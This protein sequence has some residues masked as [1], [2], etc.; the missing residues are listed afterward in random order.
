L[1]IAIKLGEEKLKL[2]LN[3]CK[4]ETNT[5]TE[6][7]KECIKNYIE[8]DN[9]ELYE[10]KFGENVTEYELYHLSTVSQNLINWYPF[11][12]KDTVLQIGGDLGELTQVFC[13]NCEKVVTIEPNI[14]KAK[15]IA[16]R[17]ENRENLEIIV[18]NIDDIILEEKFSII[19]II[20][21]NPKIKLKDNIQKLERNLKE[22][23]KFI[24]AVDNK[25]G[26][27]YFMGN[28]ENI[29]NKKFESLIGY[30]N[31]P[32]KIESFTKSSLE[33]IFNSIGYKYTFYYPLPDYKMPNVIF[34]E[35][36]KAKY[37]SIDKYN[38]YY[39]ENS[40][41]IA[42]EIDV[43]REILKT[44]QQMFEFF[45]N[46]FLIILEK[47]KN[48]ELPL[49][50]SYNNMRKEKYRLITKISKNVVEKKPVSKE[51]EGHYNNIKKNIELLQQNN[52]KTVD[53]IENG[54]IKSK[55]INQENLLNT[56]LT[57]SLEENNQQEFE[58]IIEKYIQNLKK[59]KKVEP[60]YKDTIFSKYN[61]QIEDKNI[62][63][64]LYFVE[65]GFWD[66][67][68]KNCFYIENELYFFDQE[69]RE[70]N[71]PIEYILYRSILYTISLRRYV[72]IE[73][74]FEKYHIS[75]YKNIFEA[76]DNKIQ[77]E[78]RSNKIWKFYSQNKYI[79]ID[80]SLQELHNLQIRDN[81]KQLAIEQLDKEKQEL[82]EEKQKMKI[83]FEQEKNDMKQKYDELEKLYQE[84]LYNKIYRKIKS[85]INRKRK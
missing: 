27:R 58:N 12:T 32:E 38:P 83:E 41:I 76:L 18:G 72:N 74:L 37:N 46:S 20:G 48:E 28:P 81:S 77:E 14:E 54:S 1:V 78:I 19:T 65:N 82:I 60:E 6:Q 49:Y 79:D 68:F 66:M 73:E 42:N 70:K 2:N 25:F 15:A 16:K 17:Y 45:T 50:I 80:A 53:Y 63:K 84:K 10:N 33:Q 35:K 24:I 85:T 71:V 67:T 61:I 3:F 51:A 55:Y 59:N 57:K 29:L 22:N 52:I 64:E 26:L 56:V 8:K 43:Y 36:Q 69:W 34:S 21:N 9:Q 11:N 5:I 23:G 30:N 4:N 13:N 40:T 62:L 44:D 31:E 7:E 47:E 75:K 39:K